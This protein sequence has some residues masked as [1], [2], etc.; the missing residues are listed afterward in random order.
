MSHNLTHINQFGP[1][2]TNF[3]LIRPIL[4]RLE[5]SLI[6]FDPFCCILTHFD[7]CLDLFCP[8]TPIL[9]Y[10]NDFDLLKQTG[11][12]LTLI[13]QFGHILIILNPIEQKFTQFKPILD[14]LKMTA[15]TVGTIFTHF[16]CVSKQ[17]LAQNYM[18][19]FVIPSPNNFK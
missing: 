15:C 16:L 14:I 10:V 13:V 12:M 9:S 17:N 8:F 2:L 7:P 18:H 11:H 6:Y 4:K 5:P 19:T 1:I 3:D